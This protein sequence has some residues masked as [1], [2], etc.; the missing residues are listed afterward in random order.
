M[1]PRGMALL[2]P[3]AHSRA[4]PNRRRILRRRPLIGLLT[5]PSISQ[6]ARHTSSCSSS[7]QCQPQPPLRRP[8]CSRPC[9]S[10]PHPTDLDFRCRRVQPLCDTFCHQP[11]DLTT[12]ILPPHLPPTCLTTPASVASNAPSPLPSRDV[13]TLCVPPS[14]HYRAAC[15]TWRSSSH[16][17]LHASPPLRLR[18]GRWNYGRVCAQHTAGREARHPRR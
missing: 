14:P 10:S 11:A 8:E 4:M 9:M 6:R 15:L 18:Y 13:H 3:T 5:R 7:A 16:L 1:R 2:P 17:F 12:A